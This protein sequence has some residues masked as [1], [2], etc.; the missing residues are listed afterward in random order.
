MRAFLIGCRFN[1][2]GNSYSAATMLAGD[3][4]LAP[5]GLGFLGYAGYIPDVRAYFCPS[6]INMGDEC[7]L[8]NT[9]NA[10]YSVGVS[11]FAQ[12]LKVLSTSS[13]F[14]SIMHA[15]FTSTTFPIGGWNMGGCSYAVGSA[16]NYRLS[17]AF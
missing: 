17:P 6:A 2:Q 4:N 5:Q 15:G 10:F 11:N 1:N 12:V 9:G 14:K 3:I 7:L 13:D 16:Y 8:S